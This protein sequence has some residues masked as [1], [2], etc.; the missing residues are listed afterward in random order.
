MQQLPA[1]R[2]VPVRGGHGRS[3]GRRWRSVRLVVV[4]ASLVVGAVVL[5]GVLPALAAS[6]WADDDR[7]SIAELQTDPAGDPLSVRLRW[8]ATALPVDGLQLVR[9]GQVVANVGPGDVTAVDT[10]VAGLGSRSF[11]YELRALSGT[12]VVDS[13]GPVDA[14]FPLGASDCTIVWTGAASSSWHDPANWS[15]VGVGVEPTGLPGADDIA[16]ATTTANW[17]ITVSEPGAEA[18]SLTTTLTS[19]QPTLRA[20]AGGDLAI[21]DRLQV[22]TLHLAGGD[23]ALGGD[24]MLYGTASRAAAIFGG[25]TLTLDGTLRGQSLTSSDL[26]GFV[27]TDPDTTTT[28]SGGRLEVSQL[29]FTADHKRTIVGRDGH[30]SDVAVVR[31]AGTTSFEAGPGGATLRTNQ[32][33][34]DGPTSDVDV[35]WLLGRSRAEDDAFITVDGPTR[36]A[37]VEDVDPGGGDAEWN[38]AIVRL[39]SRLDVDEPVDALLDVE[40]NDAAADLRF[41]GRSASFAGV[42]SVDALRVDTGTTVVADGDLTVRTL[43]VLAGSTLDVRG[44]IIDPNGD[45][46][47]SEGPASADVR[48]STVI[49]AEPWRVRRSG[50]L[51]LTDGTVDGDVVVDGVLSAGGNSEVQEMGAIV[52]GDLEVRPGGV[53]FATAFGT[54]PLLHTEGVVEGQLT[55][56][57]SLLVTLDQQLPDEVDVNLLA[58]PSAPFDGSP[59]GDLGQR[60]RGGAVRGRP[61]RRRH[62]PRLHRTVDRRGWDPGA[63]VQVTRVEA[64]GSGDPVEVALQWAA[65][66]RPA[67]RVRGRPRGGRHRHRGGPGG[68][69]HPGAGRPRSGGPGRLRRAGGRRRRRS[70]RRA[71]PRSRHVP[72]RRPRLHHRVDPRGGR[73]TSGPLVRRAQLGA[74]RRRRLRRPRCR[75]AGAHDR[76]PGVHRLGA[77]R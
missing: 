30:V 64:D 21:G 27:L 43:S 4:A 29:R 63:A 9:D 8:P 1:V 12:T 3:H 33:D 46:E 18:K 31:L 15:A 47:T 60:L 55:I 77:R 25:G 19:A 37:D 32:L 48:N 24:S 57:G 76:R 52:T 73:W 6:V 74:L 61:S 35:E 20:L 42:R 41:D 16:C 2:R 10:G 65:G 75:G 5:P 62:L 22:Q 44:E 38:N 71:R 17:P 14:A 23:V 13:L 70:D 11:R 39:T 50:F 72:E 28:L 45:V 36:L 51:G 68:R 26:S 69:R 67:R 49:V 7:L 34:V 53:L 59:R 54:D 56:D 40:L 58:T 66:E